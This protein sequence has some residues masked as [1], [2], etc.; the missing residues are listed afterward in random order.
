M[1]ELRGLKKEVT[2]KSL[3]LYGV[4]AAVALPTAGIAGV[5]GLS[6]GLL[7]GILLFYLLAATL[8]KAVKKNP[9]RARASVIFHYVLRYFLTYAILL[10][11]ILREDMALVWV[12]IG[13]LVIKTV[14]LGSNLYDC[15][16]VRI[17]ENRQVKKE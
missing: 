8:E 9:L 5:Y 15:W 2:R 10:T 17:W 1:G 14:I 11:A 3:I 4:L 16:K 7:M 13:I 12:L 6:F